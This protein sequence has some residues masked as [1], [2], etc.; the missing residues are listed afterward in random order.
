VIEKNIVA[1]Q[2]LLPKQ[3]AAISYVPVVW[4]VKVILERSPQLSSLNATCWP[5]AL[6]MRNTVSPL[7]AEP[8]GQAV[9]V[10]VDPVKR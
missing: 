9:T 4:A 7:L 3:P 10:M 6:N 2:L 1:L 8:S 5:E